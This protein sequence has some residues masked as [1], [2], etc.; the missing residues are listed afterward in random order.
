[1]TE[2]EAEIKTY[3]IQASM[4]ARSLGSR[5]STHQDRCLWN[6]CGKPSIEW[7]IDAIKGSKYI[8]KIVVLTESERIREVVKSLGGV[9]IIDRPL[10]TSH[11]IPRDYTKG[12]FEKEKP[13][14]VLSQ[15]PAIFNY[16]VHYS[17]YYLKRTEGYEADQIF[18]FSATAAMVT[19]GLIDRI[20]VAFFE[21]KGAESMAPFYP[22]LPYVQVAN[23]KTNRMVSIIAD[24]VERQRAIPVYLPM[25]IR[26][27]GRAAKIEDLPLEGGP[28]YILITEEEGLD[29]HNEEDRFRVRCAMKRRLLKEG[30]KVKW[31][32]EDD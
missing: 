14:S 6:I 4:R 15:D 1:M 13:R 10:W 19:T 20:I 17:K 16:L 31:S 25:S 27:E 3:H 22:I 11:Q 21:N 9:T 28:K 23:P 12:V 26:L 2:L 5:Y 30:K 24:N 8:D 18:N 29:M 32:I 7:I